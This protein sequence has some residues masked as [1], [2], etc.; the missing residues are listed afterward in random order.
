MWFLSKKASFIHFS[1]SAPFSLVFP[2]FTLVLPGFASGF[3]WFFHCDLCGFGFALVSNVATMVA[4]NPHSTDKYSLPVSPLSFSLSFTAVL[5]AAHCPVPQSIATIT[6]L[7]NNVTRQIN[8]TIAR[9]DNL[10]EIQATLTAAGN[11]A[12]AILGDIKN[13]LVCRCCVRKAWDGRSIS[14]NPQEGRE[15]KHSYLNEGTL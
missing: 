11:T 1:G 10:E 4:W 5:A 7:R 15:R 8:A 9:I 2:G 12:L 3:A 6:D 13:D 14:S